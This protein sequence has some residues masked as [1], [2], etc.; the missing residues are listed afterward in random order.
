MM[1]QRSNGEREAAVF[2]ASSVLDQVATA[3]TAIRI[4]DGLTFADMAAVLGKSEDQAAKYCAGSAAM[5]VVTFARAKREWNGRF[6]G[7]LDR[8]CV[9]SRPS[10]KP[11]RSRSSAV[12]KAALALS[13]AL[14]DDEEITPKE[15][16][17]NRG[18]IENARDSLDE[19]LRKLGP[20]E[21]RK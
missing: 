9:D 14:E 19:L 18:T 5:D 20:V 17:A 3:L 21:V 16:R 15:V 6:S 11:D 7:A 12:L 2:S 8:L 1:P 13:V 4:E 10:T